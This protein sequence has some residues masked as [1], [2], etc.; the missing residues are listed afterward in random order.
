MNSLEEQLTDTLDAAADTVSPDSV[1]PLLRPPT[2]P[3]PAPRRRWN[4]WLAPAAAAAAV[5]LVVAAALVAASGTRHDPAATGG[6]PA[7]GSAAGPP[8]YYAEVEGK[9]AGW[10]G[11]DSVEV[12]VRSSTTGAVAARVKNP[13]IP[14]VPRVL[15]VSVAAAPGERTFYVLYSNY[16]QH[17]T[18]RIYRFR[19]TSAGPTAPVPIKGGVI[20]GQ[21][22]LGNVGGFT[23]SPDGSRLAVAVASTTDNTI[24]ASIAR[25]I[26][27]IDLR[28]GARQAWQGGLD[29]AGQPFGIESL[30]WTPDGSSL[31]FLAQWCPPH[32]ISYGVYGGFICSTLGQ[33]NQHPVRTEGSD[34]VREI[35]LAA[36]GGSLGSG[37][38][39]TRASA[40]LTPGM[41]VV[42]AAD[43]KNLVTIVPAG[44]GHE[45]VTISM[46]TGAITGR[47]GPV[48]G[49]FFS[50]GGGLY[51]TTDP[52][53]GYVLAWQEGNSVKPVHGYVH[54]GRYH[55]L[56]PVFGVRYPGGWIQL[57]W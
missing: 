7:A 5:V 43:G 47:L 42:A 16:G 8:R 3:R 40:K 28:T 1:R 6:D 20:T 49:R 50:G 33:D 18:T 23:V 45:V 2:I 44:G 53:S 54:A 14:G 22:F 21:D 27:V 11:T 36:G 55:A 13:V 48:P 4:A 39:L 46:T 41:P 25:K 26:V 24:N 9:F 30:S 12:V 29:R 52:A 10:H 51:L 37:R 32:D 31:V 15:P 56:A 35:S 57:A 19:L 34:E 38:A 17:D